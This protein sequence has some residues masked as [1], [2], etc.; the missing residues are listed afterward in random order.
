MNRRPPLRIGY[1]FEGPTDERTIPELVKQLLERPVTM[2]PL[3]KMSSG[4]EDFRRPS[5]QDL[6]A[7]R[8]SPRWGMFKSYVKALL[9]EGAEVI[10]IVAD[11]DADEDIGHQELFPHKRWCML[12]R[13]L[14]FN[15][16]PDLRLVDTAP[17]PDE[18]GAEPAQ[19]RVPLCEARGLGMDCFPDCVVAAYEDGIVPVIIGIARQM[20]EAWLLAQPEVVEAVLWEPLSDEDR[21][22]CEEPEK[23]PHPKNEIIRRYNGGG[24]LSGQQAE[25][26]GGHPE[27]SAAVIEAR[28][29]SFARFA[30]DVRILLVVS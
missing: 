29:P 14:P 23:I 13:N 26:I 17:Q 25:D 9:I 19:Q 12:G 18:A 28:C 8:Q 16:R 4:W 6:R 11:H 7:G 10:V 15:E 2:I 24:D 3:R 30:E 21:A 22:R 1:I 27:F 20:L 5:P